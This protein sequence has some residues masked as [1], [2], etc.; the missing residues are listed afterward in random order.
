VTP[1]PEHEEP[2]SVLFVCTANIGRSAYAERRA[3]QLL[4]AAGES[5][6][7]VAS[8]GVP[9]YPGREMD[10]PMAAELRAR[11]GDPLGHV[12]QSVTHDL[13]EE[14]H[15][16]LTFEFAHRLRI[17]ESWPDQEPKVF[18]VR[19]LADAISRVQSP[20]HGFELLDQ[21]LAVSQLDGLNWDVRD[22]HRR[23]SKAARVCADTIDAALEVILP[24]LAPG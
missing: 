6:V 9:G 21:A 12:S 11:G 15:L 20:T 23:G 2:V 13:L 18:A 1:S 7:R 17:A 5:H 10:P 16:V 3:A 22:P 24:A 19:R 4:A 8:A 14:A